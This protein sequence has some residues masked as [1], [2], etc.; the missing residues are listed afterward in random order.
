MA[1]DV[2]RGNA[3]AG[4]TLR[5]AKALA[6]TAVGTWPERAEFVSLLSRALSREGGFAAA[7]Y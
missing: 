6:E 5:E 3:G 7:R 2:L 4:V 1:A